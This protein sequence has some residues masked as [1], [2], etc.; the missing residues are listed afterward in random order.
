MTPTHHH[1]SVYLVG[2]T[3]MSLYGMRLLVSDHAL[4]KTNQPKR[5]HAAKPW[6]RGRCYHKR[7]QKK[8]AK[9]FGMV[10]KPCYFQLGRNTLIAHPSIAKEIRAAI[11]KETP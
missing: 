3:G 6:M 9:R 7:I 8:W 11:A 1:N 4:E 10:M 5:E 2:R